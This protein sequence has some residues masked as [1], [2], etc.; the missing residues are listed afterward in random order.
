MYELEIEK[1]GLEFLISRPSG[2]EF[3]ALGHCYK[4]S[5]ECDTFAD[6]SAS[7]WLFVLHSLSPTG[8]SAYKTN[9]FIRP[10]SQPHGCV[11]WLLA[12]N[13][14]M[15]LLNSVSSQTEPCGD[16]NNRMRPRHSEELDVIITH[17]KRLSRLSRKRLGRLSLG[18]C[19]TVHRSTTLKCGQNFD[20]SFFYTHSE[21]FLLSTTSN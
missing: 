1:W 11:L 19:G 3:E 12:G 13:H 15:L 17:R 4:V 16:G 2:A 8:D 10:H 5:T 21:L 14:G 9:I 20:N 7:R 18:N 6:S